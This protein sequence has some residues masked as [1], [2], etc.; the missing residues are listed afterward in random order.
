MNFVVIKCF[1]P[2]AE[3][4]GRAFFFSVPCRYWW[5]CLC[6]M[7]SVINKWYCNCVM[8]CHG[9]CKIYCNCV[10]CCRLSGKIYLIVWH[11]VM[12]MV[13][14]GYCNCVTCCHG[15]VQFGYCNQVCNWL[16]WSCFV[17]DLHLTYTPQQHMTGTPHQHIYKINNGFWKWCQAH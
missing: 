13:K 10:T 12:A 8:C 3:S 9:Y 6:F 2:E 15:N 16:L 11:V 17:F 1:Y 14:F 4:I 7:Y 5:Y